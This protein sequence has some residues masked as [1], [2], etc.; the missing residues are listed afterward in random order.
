MIKTIGQNKAVVD[1]VK[2][3]ESGILSD[4]FLISKV[5]NAKTDARIKYP[6]YKSLDE[7]VN[8]ER[9][10]SLDEYVT[11]KIK[12]R[13][14]TKAEEYF[15]NAY[16]LEAD[17][18]H[19]PGAREIWL[20]RPKVI[21]PSVYNDLDKTELWERTED[22]ENFSP[23]IDFIETLPFKATGRMLIIY[24]DA[25]RP[26]P[27]HR[28]HL[29]TD[30]CY[31]FIWFRTKLNKPFYMLNHKTREKKYVESYSAWFD[32]VNQFHGVDPYDGFSFSVRVDGIF[33]DEFRR[34]IPKPSFNIASTPALWA[35]IQS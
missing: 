26:V 13:I 9:L 23:L 2:N 15:L 7:F 28:D 20:S 25:A 21:Q 31:E 3:P 16:R 29:D 14:A 22:A 1:S 30:I 18:L 4:E 24:D 19:Q 10:K 5:D 27:A 35:C 17:S 11:D 32:S 12:E 8:V 34:H 33:T 6:S